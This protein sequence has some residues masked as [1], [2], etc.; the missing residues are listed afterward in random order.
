MGFLMNDLKNISR[1]ESLHKLLFLHRDGLSSVLDYTKIASVLGQQKGNFLATPRMGGSGSWAK[2]VVENFKTKNPTST[3]E[4]Q[5]LQ[6]LL[7]WHR[8]DNALIDA[9]NGLY[10]WLGS[11]A[12]TASQLRSDPNV[13][14]IDR[15]NADRGYPSLNQL[16]VLDLELSSSVELPKNVGNI[17]TRIAEIVG[18]FARQSSQVAILSRY[19]T[20]SSKREQKSETLAFLKSICRQAKGG[21]LKEIF[22]YTTDEGFFSDHGPHTLDRLTQKLQITLESDGGRDLLGVLPPEGIIYLVLDDR[23]A[24][25]FNLHTRLIL[26]NHVNFHTAEDI[27]SKNPQM[28]TRTAY[29]KADRGMWEDL[30]RRWFREHHGMKVRFRLR[31]GKTVANKVRIENEP[32]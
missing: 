29:S 12:S 26:T 13:S 19:N 14:V 21:L 16:D 5:K 10:A 1:S 17:S 23:D 2:Y 22:L 8:K 32:K 15:P 7:V 18:P 20:L 28:I 4:A 25:E 27:S 24:P 11:W 30:Q 3:F 9:D 31:I 6:E